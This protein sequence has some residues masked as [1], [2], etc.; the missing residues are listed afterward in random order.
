VSKRNSD[1]LDF[2]SNNI[3]TSSEAVDSI[4]DD[5][6]SSVEVFG[7]EKSIHTFSKLPEIVGSGFPY[8]VQIRAIVVSPREVN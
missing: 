8:I 1:F 3:S 7:T 4:L 6:E 2:D 5:F